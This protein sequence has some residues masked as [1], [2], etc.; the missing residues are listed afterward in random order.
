[1]WQIKMKIKMSTGT[2]GSKYLFSKLKIW[3][4]RMTCL[5]KSPS[6]DG[7][8]R[9]IDVYEDGDTFLR[10]VGNP[11]QV[12]MASQ[13]RKQSG[14]LR[15]HYI[16][17]W[18]TREHCVALLLWSTV[19]QWLPITAINYC[20]NLTAKHP[21]RRTD[22]LYVPQLHRLFKA[23]SFTTSEQKC[24]MWEWESHWTVQ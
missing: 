20:V 23:K 8:K 22:R 18:H 15:R 14:Y 5:L 3:P 11:P 10:N 6:T 9:F 24:N 12:H 19:P 13:P 16:F 1:M 17:K 21:A 2:E 4:K 7:L